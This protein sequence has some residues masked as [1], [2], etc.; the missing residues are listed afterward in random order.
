MKDAATSDNVQYSVISYLPYNISNTYYTMSDTFIIQWTSYQ[1]RIT[2]ALVRY[3]LLAT[4]NIIPWY[5]YVYIFKH[6][7]FVL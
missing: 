1:L 4:Y 5:I 3:L 6:C 7:S 2:Q